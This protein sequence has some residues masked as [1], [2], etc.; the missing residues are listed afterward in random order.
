[1]HK[2]M[3]SQQEMWNFERMAKAIRYLC[4]HAQT[5]PSLQQIADHVHMSPEH[6]QKVFKTWVGATPKQFM[7]FIR[8]QE[9]K[10]CLQEHS[11][12]QTVAKMELSST[13]RL[14]D[15]FVRLEGMT[16]AEYQGGAARLNIAYQ[17]ITTPLGGMCL[18]STTK[19]ICHLQFC[20][21][22][23]TGLAALQ[24]QFP[25]AKLEPQHIA[26][27]E[28]IQQFIGHK[29][30]LPQP[31][32]L[33]VKASP[34]QLKVWESLLKIP[35]GVLKSYGALAG[36]IGHP[37]ASRAIGTAIGANPIAFL[38]PCHRV[39]RASGALGGY[40]WGEERKWALIYQEWARQQDQ[41]ILA[42]MDR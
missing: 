19:G 12:R 26:Q 41:S 21:D 42:L 17:F 31:L 38:I 35:E 7:Q 23:P 4:T 39:I 22:E 20:V 28:S 14:H 36:E 3:S 30:S 5:Q 27:A 2:L 24:A 18:G 32:V 16:P 9:A 37:K 10:K 8:L 15:L 1:M 11:V 13:A 29:V 33:H 6:F 25:H 34:F 40:R